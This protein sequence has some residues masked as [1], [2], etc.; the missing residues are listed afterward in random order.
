[1]NKAGTIHTLLIGESWMVHTVEAK[2]FDTFTFDSYGVGT[3]YIEPVLSA[4]GFSFTHMPSHRV[5]LDFPKTVEAL[6]AYDVIIISDVGANTFLLPAETFS[7]CERSVNKLKLLKD[8]VLSGGGLLMA[9][10]YLSFMG[11]E[12]KGKYHDSVLEEVLPVNFLSHDDRMEHP[13]GIDVS[14]D[15]DAHPIFEG[16]G[17]VLPGILGYNKAL[18]KPGCPV[19]ATIE[20]DP[21]IVLGEYGKGRSIAYATD[22]APHWSSPEF[23]QSAAYAALWRNMVRYLSGRM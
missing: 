18:A 15:P 17:N 23:C 11:I 5:T 14:I 3:E 19:I 16:V 9:G 12:G 22:V 2:G 21:L 8:Y 6:H 20:N 4:E 7:Q 13:E 1:M 10:G